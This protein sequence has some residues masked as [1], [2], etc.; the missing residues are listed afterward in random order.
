LTLETSEATALASQA[1][2]RVDHDGRGLVD[3]RPARWSAATLMTV[4]SLAQLE[5][6]LYKSR[7]AQW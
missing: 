5:A 6:R 1:K 2:L 7:P 3:S 4:D